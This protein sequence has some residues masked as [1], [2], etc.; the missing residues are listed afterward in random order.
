MTKKIM[1]PSR[2]KNITQRLHR[3]D[4]TKVALRIER[5][6]KMIDYQVHVGWAKD[7]ERAKKHWIRCQMGW[8]RVQP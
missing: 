5:V 8:S 7:I 4:Q 2:Y 6:K 3:L 1:T